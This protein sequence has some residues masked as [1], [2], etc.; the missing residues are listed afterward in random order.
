MALKGR[1]SKETTVADIMTAEVFTVPSSTGT[2]VC[3]ALMNEK[4]F[5]HLPVVDGDKVLGLISMRDIMADVI[6]DHEFTI[7]Q[8]ETYVSG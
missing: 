7:N 4:H 2:R 1:N 3:M 8:L 5:R 6:A